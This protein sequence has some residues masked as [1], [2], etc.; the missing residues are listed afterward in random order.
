MVLAWKKG[1]IN[2][3]KE[4]QEAL[5]P[6]GLAWSYEKGFLNHRNERLMQEWREFFESL[7]ASVNV[8]VPDGI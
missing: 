7:Q 5:F 1:G 8:G 2:E 4:L 3:R 6:D